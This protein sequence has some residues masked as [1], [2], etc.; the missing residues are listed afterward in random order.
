MMM[1][2]L[3]NFYKYAAQFKQLKIYDKNIYNKYYFY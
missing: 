3:M 2:N 1:T